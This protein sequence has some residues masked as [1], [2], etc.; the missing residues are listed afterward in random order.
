MWFAE[1]IYRI[2]PSR[3]VNFVAEGDAGLHADTDRIALRVV[4]LVAAILLAGLAF[5]L[6]PV[7]ALVS[8]FW[9]G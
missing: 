9:G 6:L 1:N 3:L 7:V 5:L 2:A 4:L 8:L